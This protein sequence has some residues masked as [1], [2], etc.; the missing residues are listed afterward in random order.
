M[1]VEAD[2]RELA[3]TLPEGNEKPCYGTPGFY[4]KKKLFARLRED[5]T[6]LMVYRESVEE[7]EALIQTDP[8][9]FFTTPHYDGHAMVLVHLGAVDREELLDLLEESWLLRAPKRLAAELLTE[10]QR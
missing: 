5:P 9:K 6:E 3:L 10:G 7:K 1:A 2:V 4:V 8:E